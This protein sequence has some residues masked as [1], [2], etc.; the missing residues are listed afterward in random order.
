MSYHILLIGPDGDAAK[1]LL[2]LFDC[3]IILQVEHCL[4]PVRAGCV[5]G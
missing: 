5:W 4:L 3:E 2:P 1:D